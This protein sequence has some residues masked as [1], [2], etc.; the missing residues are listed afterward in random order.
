MAEIYVTFDVVGFWKHDE[1]FVAGWNWWTHID[2]F[3]TSINYLIRNKFWILKIIQIMF[4]FVTHRI[5]SLI[6]F[7]IIWKMLN[8][9][10]INIV[11]TS[12]RIWTILTHNFGEWIS[13]FKF[14]N[15]SNFVILTTQ[16][17]LRF[18]FDSYWWMKWFW[19]LAQCNHKSLLV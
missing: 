16:E 9:D 1:W 5:W 17:C 19:I 15:V 3:R 10:S 12:E 8:F 13:E 11:S 18:I 7:Y 14:L 6:K 2:E 4:E